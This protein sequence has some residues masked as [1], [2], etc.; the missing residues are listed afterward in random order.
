[1]TE[2]R[3][4]VTNAVHRAPI[5]DLHTHLF[6]P[7]FVSLQ[8]WGVDDLLTYHYLVAETFRAKPSLSP[9][10]FFGWSKSTKADFIWQVLFVD[11]IPLS[12]ATSGVAKVFDAFGLNTRARDLREARGFYAERTLTQHLDDVFRIAGVESVVMT[13][14]PL[15]P[16]ERPY[17]ES[18]TEV[19]PRFHSALRI[20]P[21]LNDWKNTAG[22]LSDL[23]FA[24]N[25]ELDESTIANV[26]KFI[27]IWIKRMNPRYVAVSLPDTFDYPSN[28]TRAA[29]LDQAVLPACR[30]HNLPLAM[31]IG[32]RRAV[33]PRL[34]GAGDG[35]G[36]ADLGAVER[37][38]RQYE[39]VR[40][41]VTTL[42]AANV[43]DLCVS[44]RKFANILPFGCWWFMNNPSLVEATTLLRLEMLG[45][46]F[47]PQHSDARVLDHL[48]YKWDHSRQSIAS[49]LARRLDDIESS[50]RSPSLSEIDRLSEA[51][52]G[53]IAR[54][55]LGLSK[56]TNANEAF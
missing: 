16:E 2:V 3:L 13:N 42:A 10:T 26:R 41:L 48:I 33:N 28:S 43:H 35:M 1:M 23:G 11:S 8:S 38:A 19:D 44:A 6:S 32:V 56:D 37:L 46:T 27:E 25:P 47:V 53:G 36:V 50:G 51:L 12:E 9:E 45:A 29:L 52:T 34:M 22:K 40:F 15:D 17:W 39:N 20:D 18:G 5:V 4:N 30:D 14:D 31:M 24:A 21:V 49:A 54:N 7:G 55:W